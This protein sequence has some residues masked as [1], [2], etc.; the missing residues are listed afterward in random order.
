MHQRSHRRFG[1]AR[2]LALLLTLALVVPASAQI[3]S[4]DAA[5]QQAAKNAQELETLTRVVQ[6]MR[7]RLGA[8]SQQQQVL[9]Q[10][11]RELSGA[12]QEAGALNRQEGKT[13]EQR[14]LEKVRVR[15]AEA[16]T[17]RQALSDKITELNKQVADMGQYIQLPP[18]KD[19]YAAAF[20]AYQKRDYAEAEAGF[21]RMLKYYPKGQFNANARYWMSQGF[22]AQKKYT[23][24][25]EAA[26]QIIA[27]H[28]AS[29][30]VPD[31]MLILA[32]ALHKL[33]MP[34]KSRETLRQLIERYPTTLAADKARQLSP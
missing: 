17:T 27:L 30:K 26:R 28:G 16:E 3:F 7:T 1:S 6:N 12:I 31:A 9:A 8:V 21:G 20:G 24:A 10:E 2:R 13:L 25:A 11:I 29:D 32:Q 18:E 33:D 34:D 5:R 15:L 19:M 23:E 4:D 14:L 22:V